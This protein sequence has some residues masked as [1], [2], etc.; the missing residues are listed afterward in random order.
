MKLTWSP[1]ARERAADIDAWWREERP[2]APHRF[3]EE[4]IAAVRYIL[5]YPEV[6]PVYVELD[7]YAVR[8][9]LLK[10][11][12]QH[13]YYSVQPEKGR[14]WIHLIWGTRREDPP[15]L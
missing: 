1:A 9:V 2:A 12:R 6:P 5:D 13:V 14:I 10:K 8:R 4:L 11:T 3:T 7:G 15:P